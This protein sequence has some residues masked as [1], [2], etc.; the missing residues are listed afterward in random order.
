MAIRNI[1]INDKRSDE[2]LIG[3]LN[4][5]I[6]G[7]EN[8]PRWDNNGPIQFE[9][10]DNENPIKESFCDKYGVHNVYKKDKGPEIVGQMVDLEPRLTEEQ[11]NNSHI[12]GLDLEEAI[13][14]DSIEDAR[15]SRAYTNKMDTRMRTQKNEHTIEDL[16]KIAKSMDK[17]KEY[18]EVNHPQHYNN[19]DVEVI[20]MM[21]RVFGKSQ[22]ATFC[23]LNAFKYRMRAGTKPGQS[24]SK[25]LDKERWYLNKFNELKNK[26]TEVHDLVGKLQQN[27][28]L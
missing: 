28:Q 24:V 23:K 15:E 21:E 7:K 9:E 2:E 12:W 20:D 19:Y 14:N 6:S 5:R 22:T 18:E 26:D 10:Q 17:A 1:K 25:D 8:T 4:D 27:G 13:E 3:R 16:A 11:R